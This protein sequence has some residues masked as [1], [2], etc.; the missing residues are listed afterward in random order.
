MV[1]PVSASLDLSVADGP[2]LDLS[3]VPDAWDGLLMAI[4]SHPNELALVCSHQPHDL[5]GFSS[6]GPSASQD[7]SPENESQPYLR[8]T[9]QTL[10]Q[11]I[12][13]LVVAKKSIVADA[14]LQEELGPG[15]PVV[16]FLQ[17]GADFVLAAW[18]S[19]ATGCTLTPLNPLS[20]KNRDE[21][22]H[23]LRTALSLAPDGHGLKFVYAAISDVA[24]DIDELGIDNNIFGPKV[25]KILVSGSKR[26]EG[27]LRLEDLMLSIDGN[28]R[29]DLCHSNPILGLEGEDHAQAGIVLL[30]V[31]LKLTVVSGTWRC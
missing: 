27:W 28:G 16:T 17:N 4:K 21:A 9:F 19:V 12:H 18:A 7:T 14:D 29:S 10:A 5:F 13:K 31:N 1:A 15:T 30:Y 23:M 6:L 22:A 26:R 20:L 2:P 25:V 24:R 11:A 8:W 3:G